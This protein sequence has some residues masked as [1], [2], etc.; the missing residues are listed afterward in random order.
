[1]HA[2]LIFSDISYQSG[3]IKL[4]RSTQ[5]NDKTVLRTIF[6]PKISADFISSKL[7]FIWLML[8]VLVTE[9]SLEKSV[10]MFGFMIACLKGMNH[11]VLYGKAKLQNYMIYNLKKLEKFIIDSLIKNSLFET[12]IFWLFKLY[13][14]I[15]IAN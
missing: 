8:S 9:L 13:A 7:L 1:M 3:I 11:R 12:Y 10:L 5:T 4:Y 2:R 15:C 6:E 14:F